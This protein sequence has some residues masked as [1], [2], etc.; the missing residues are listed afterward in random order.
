MS[1][2]PQPMED[3]EASHQVLFTSGL[4]VL[5]VHKLPVPLLFYGFISE[6]QRGLVK[7]F[8]YSAGTPAWG[9]HPPDIQLLR[10]LMAF[11]I[12]YEI[13]SWH[14]MK[15]PITSAS[16]DKKI[17]SFYLKLKCSL[18]IKIWTFKQPRWWGLW[19]GYASLSPYKFAATYWKVLAFDY[20]LPS[21]LLS[22]V[23]KRKEDL[24]YNK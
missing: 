7:I 10:D 11:L 2:I 17:N 22:H 3:K 14:V 24:F 21:S 12:L 9:G 15:S 19:V 13:N 20:S 5:V 23:N 1:F 8:C 16:T 6:T 4:R 18:L